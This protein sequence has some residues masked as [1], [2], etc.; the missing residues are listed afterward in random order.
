MDNLTYAGNL[1]NLKDL[2][3]KDNYTTKSKICDFDS[4]KLVLRNIKFK[5]K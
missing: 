1:V 5:T 4:V 2:E 3:D